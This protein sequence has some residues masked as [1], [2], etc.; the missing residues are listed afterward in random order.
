MRKKFLD[1]VTCLLFYSI[2][3]GGMECNFISA[4]K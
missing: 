2:T 4:I 3:G 1:D